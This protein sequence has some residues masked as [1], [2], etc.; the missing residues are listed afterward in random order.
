[1]HLF[2][3]TIN[4]VTIHV[5]LHINTHTASSRGRSSA[6]P[7]CGHGGSVAGLGAERRLPIA[8]CRSGAVVVI[9]VIV[10]IAIVIIVIIVVIIVVVV[11]I[12][13][14]GGVFVECGRRVSVSPRT[15]RAG[16]VSIC[17]RF[18]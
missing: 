8:V 10:I 13:F 15:H 4:L 5:H 16:L 14:V 3:S 1:V 7:R 18:T 6:L 17:S 11:V 9:I 2:L 12:S